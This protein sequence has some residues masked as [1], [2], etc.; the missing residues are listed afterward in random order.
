[1]SNDLINIATSLMKC[2]TPAV[3]L[4]QWEGPET[5][6]EFLQATVQN[7][8]AIDSYRNKYQGGTLFSTPFHLSNLYNPVTFLNALRQQTS[9][10][11][12]FYSFT[13]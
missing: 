7:A 12:F 6:Q 5:P 1:M 4:S 11:G 2:E 9:R 13:F 10:K 3:W 8:I